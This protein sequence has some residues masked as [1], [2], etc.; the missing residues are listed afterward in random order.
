MNK[1]TTRLAVRI[2]QREEATP[3]LE[4]DYITD[5]VTE[6]ANDQ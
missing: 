5:V 1:T 3:A 6:V 2:T 4:E